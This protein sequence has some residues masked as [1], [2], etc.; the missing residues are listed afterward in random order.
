[1]IMSTVLNEDRIDVEIYEVDET[2]HFA[3]RE[4]QDFTTKQ[5]CRKFIRI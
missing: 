5:M 3:Y 2:L 4:C 1:M